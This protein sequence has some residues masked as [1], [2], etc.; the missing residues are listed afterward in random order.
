MQQCSFFSPS[1]S[2]RRPARSEFIG[3]FVKVN[4][5]LV[6]RRGLLHNTCQL[7]H[8]WPFSRGRRHR[9]VLYQDVPVST[10]H[11]PTSST[12]FSVLLCPRYIFYKAWFK[13]SSQISYRLRTNKHY[14]FQCLHGKWLLVREMQV[15]TVA[16]NL[17]YEELLLFMS[18]VLMYVDCT[19]SCMEC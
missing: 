10:P 1:K 16:K 13:C 15:V 5:N 2:P 19:E 7:S 12:S 17:Q 4:F 14:P 18:Y 6:G 8:A 9:P 3:R 11:Q